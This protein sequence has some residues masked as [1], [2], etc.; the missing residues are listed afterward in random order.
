ML[1]PPRLPTSVK[2]AVLASALLLMIGLTNGAGDGYLTGTIT[3]TT[4]ARLEGVTISAQIDGE[5]ITTSVYTG[6][7]GRYF[8]PTMKAASYRVWAQTAGY[9]RS[10]ATV[11]LGLQSKRLDFKLKADADPDRLLVQLS[12]YQVLAALPEDTVAHRRGKAIFQKS[13]LYC[14]AASTAL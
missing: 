3:S 5:P 12:G 14:H 7:D 11:A 9:E 1:I 2:G 6:S 13:C 10:D 8:F 4:G